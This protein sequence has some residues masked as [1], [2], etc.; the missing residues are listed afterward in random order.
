MP[1][2]LR[3][4]TEVWFRLLIFLSTSNTLTTLNFQPF[5]T[6]IYFLLMLHKCPEALKTVTISRMLLQLANK[7]SNWHL[8]RTFN[9]ARA[10]SSTNFNL[11]RWTE[12]CNCFYFFIWMSVCWIRVTTQDYENVFITEMDSKGAIIIRW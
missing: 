2:S 4:A 7:M 9:L 10:M 12:T 6:F 1:I 5:S 8:N 3:M 11:F